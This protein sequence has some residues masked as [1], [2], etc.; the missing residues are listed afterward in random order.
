MGKLTEIKGKKAVIAGYMLG[1]LVDW[2]SV[3]RSSVSAVCVWLL[4]DNPKCRGQ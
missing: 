4:L 2:E 1:S 3:F